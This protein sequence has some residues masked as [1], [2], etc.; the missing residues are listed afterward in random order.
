[1]A[2]VLSQECAGQEARALPG[3]PTSRLHTKAPLSAG[4]PGGS[5]LS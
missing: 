1:M 2:I 3:S 5:G 4:K